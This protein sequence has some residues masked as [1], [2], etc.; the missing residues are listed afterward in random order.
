MKRSAK[1]FSPACRPRLRG[2]QPSQLL[3]VDL[4]ALPAQVTVTLGQPSIRQTAERLARLT[5]LG[6]LNADERLA[7]GVTSESASL[8]SRRSA[9][10]DIDILMVGYM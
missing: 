6:A 1:P 9:W 5:D 10:S 3:V 2:H 8:F 4:V 7:N